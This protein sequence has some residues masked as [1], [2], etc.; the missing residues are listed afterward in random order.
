[1]LAADVA[2][3]LFRTGMPARQRTSTHVVNPE[4]YRLTL[5]ALHEFNASFLP[6]ARG[7]GARAR[8]A[9]D[10]FA[11]AVDI[12]PLNAPA[13]TGVSTA[14]GQLAVA[15]QIPFD[16]GYE[17][18]SAAAMRA[19]DMDSTQGM[20]WANLAMM[21]AMKLN[22]LAVGME[23]LKKA[24][25][26][27]PSNAAIYR[28]K[29]ALLRSAHL[30]DQAIDVARIARQLDPLTSGYLDREAFTELCA[31]RAERALALYRLELA[32]NNSD[33]LARA[34]LTRSLALFGRY[35]EAIASWREEALASGDSLLSRSLAKAKGAEGYWG[36]KHEEGRQRLAALKLR[37]GYV[38]PVRFMQARW[39]AGDAAGGFHSLKAA[40]TTDTKALYRLPCM[41]EADE[42]RN[43]PQFAAAVARVGPLPL[44]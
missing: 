8:A 11:R 32:M 10:L 30:W 19:L 22:S 6:S 27:D 7:T 15:D 29:N 4:S 36:L 35:D 1:M 34:G 39:A 9:G 31:G 16:E 17:R 2:G 5:E 28:L 12:D 23:L 20:A 41:V 42:F 26:V 14:W 18:A 37:T 40:A 24:E 44:R 3:A 25:A 33:A 38:S 21:R 13:W 43:T